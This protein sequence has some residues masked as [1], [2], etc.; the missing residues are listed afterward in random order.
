MYARARLGGLILGLVILLAPAAST[1]AAE[2]A[3]G[4][5]PVLDLPQLEAMALKYSPMVKASR[6]EVKF[7]EEQKNEAHAYR[8]PQLDYTATT[9]VVPDAKLGEILT[10]PSRIFYPDPIDKIRG[11]NIFGHLDFSVIQPLYTFGKIAFREEAAAHYVKVKEEAVAAQQ[12][13]IVVL[14]SQAYYGLILADQGK[15]AVKEARSYL[16]DTRQRVD[17]LIAMNSPNAKETDRYRVAAY[18]GALEKSSA[19]AEEGS[20]TAYRAL[21]AL[22]GY[23]EGQDFKVPQDLPAPSAPAGTLDTYIQTS[24]EL[25]PEFRELK[26]GLAARQLLVDAAKADRLPSFFFAVVGQLAG[27]PG[28]RYNPDPY[29]TDYFNDNGALPMLGA[30]WH[31]DFGILKAKIGEAKAEL[32]QLQEDQRTA[33][34]GIPVE[35]AKN[36]GDVRQYYQSSVGME[37]A[38]VN[39]RRWLVTSLSNFDMGLGKMDDIFQAF[40]R[41]GV[42]RGD[43]LMALYQYNLSVAK[44]DKATGAYRRKLPAEGPAIKPAS[45]PA[46][47]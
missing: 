35:V 31:F 18:E 12:G 13:E 19:E 21:K 46:P 36:Y 4:A 47:R 3:K 14:V 43:Y 22:I 26:E 42:F 39:S 25:R 33:L 16:S 29:V 44:L 34:M 23:G 8:W 11:V 10:V 1:K 17:R 37:K 7:A 32:E 27:A 24:L 5:E 28:R 30:K 41:Y 6:S 40:E 45:Y 20:R 38:Y 2:P 15:E 9:G